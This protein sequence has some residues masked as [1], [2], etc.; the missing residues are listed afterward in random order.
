M[1]SQFHC[2]QVLEELTELIGFWVPFNCASVALR[3]KGTDLLLPVHHIA[4][5]AT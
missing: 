3:K 4:A 2:E 1:G 5:V